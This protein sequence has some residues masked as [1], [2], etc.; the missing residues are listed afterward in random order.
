MADY[1]LVLASR[2]ERQLLCHF[3]FLLRVSAPAAKR[4]R[5]EFGDTLSE[6][7]AN[8]FQ[9]PWEQDLNLPEGLYRTALFSKRYKILFLVENNTVYI[10]AVV[11]CRQNI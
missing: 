3:E 10:D 1:K 6:L 9:F 7:A 2:V 8:P 4:F 11:D 5:R